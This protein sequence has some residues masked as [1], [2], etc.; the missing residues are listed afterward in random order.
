MAYSVFQKKYILRQTKI[1]KKE[2][3]KF[4]KENRG[5]KYMVRACED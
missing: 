3:E 2:E 4:A 5:I 1:A